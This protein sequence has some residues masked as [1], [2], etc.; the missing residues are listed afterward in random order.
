[1]TEEKV[2]TKQGTGE[3]YDATKIKVLGGIEAVRKRPAMYIGDTGTRGFHHLVYE[4]V[5]NS[6]DEAMAGYGNRIDVKINTDGS[7]SVTDNA[8]GIPVGMHKEMKKSALEV[9]LTTLHAGGKFDH[10]SYKVSGGLHG[11]GLSVVNALSEWLEVE[12]RNEGH[13]CRQ[14]YERGLPVT[15]VTTLGTS[16]TT[17]TKVTFKPDVEIFGEQSFSFDV[18]ANRMRELAF[19]NAGLEIRIKQEG[20][21][22]EERFKFDG[23]IKAFIRYLNEG[24]ETL[25]RDVIYLNAESNGVQVEV[26]LQYNDSYGETISSYVNNINT[27]EG[28]THLSGFRSALTRTVNQYAKQGGLL[29]NNQ[30]PSGDDLRE[31]LAA[32]VSA[33]VPDPQFEG[34]T[35]TKLGNSEVEGIVQTVVNEQLGA[36]LEEHP[37]TA[38]Q[39]ASKAIQAALAREAAR[40]ARDLTRRKGALTS[41]SLPT[42]LADCTT[43]DVETS[44]LYLVEGDSAGGS[45][46]MGRDRMFQAILPLRGKILNVEKARVDKMLNNEEIRTIISAL[47]TGIITADFDLTKLRYGKTIIMTDADVDGSHIRI[48][49]LTFFFRQMPELLRDGRVYVAQPP[50]FRVKWKSREI[51]YVNER[52]MKRDLLNLGIEGV[53]LKGRGLEGEIS[54]KSLRELMDLLVAIEEQSAAIQRWGLSLEEYLKLERD[55][56]LPEFKVLLGME[57]RFCYGE[58]ERNAMLKEEQAR[59]GKEVVIADKDEARAEAG[60]TEEKAEGE[61]PEEERGPEVEVLELHGARELERVGKRL[62]TRGFTL[63]DCVANGEKK[64][65][66][67]KYVLTVDG[68]E[69]GGESLLEMLKLVRQAGQKGMDIQR[70]KGLGEMNAEQLWETTMDPAKR[71]LLRVKLEDA[72]EADRMFTILMGENVEPRREFIEKHALEVRFLDV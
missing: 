42:K 54:G 44:E 4:V 47:G 55:E 33:R 16:K 64:P 19:L 53:S 22:R 63:A 2:G 3:K 41:G 5:D 40:K 58:D 52:D 32:V 29:K 59:L 48:L 46:K 38:R 8:R 68:K 14:E 25:H 13:V 12:V 70:Y 10:T 24:K 34:Q 17:G 67:P 18:L 51:Y 9:V 62:K 61:E 7:V 65:K 39:I 30:A 26:A 6:V 37:T 36:Y 1:M 50:L 49:L 66:Q 27:V 28:G 15:P 43:K 20:T 21:E 31:G 57:E 56:K 45:A 11:V 23:G 71:T 72:A 60:K 35:K 69:T